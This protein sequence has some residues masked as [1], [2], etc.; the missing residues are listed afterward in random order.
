MSDTGEM[1][2]SINELVTIST[3]LQSQIEDCL[4]YL[5][6]SD[7]TIADK[8]R[9]SNVIQYSKS[10]SARIN[11]IFKELDFNPEKN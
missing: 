4:E 6:D 3:A 1:I 8:V 2:F 11:T 5:T 7:L 10:A 9:L